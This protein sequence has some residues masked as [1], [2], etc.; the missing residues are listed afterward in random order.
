MRRLFGFAVT[1]QCPC[2]ACGILLIC[3]IFTI[4]LSRSYVSMCH[5][6]G[7]YVQALQVGAGISIGLL[8]FTFQD[9]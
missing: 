5:S 4:V 8:I 7:Q 6:N 1:F 9:L 3:S 2:M